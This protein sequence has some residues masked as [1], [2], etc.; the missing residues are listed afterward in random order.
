MTDREKNAIDRW[1]AERRA[2]APVALRES[3]EKV[4]HSFRRLGSTLLVEGH[5]TFVPN[6]RE[7]ELDCRG[8]DALHIN[9]IGGCLHTGLRLFNALPGVKVATIRNQ[10]LSAA[11]LVAMA[12]Q[13]VRIERSAMMMLHTPT[14]A[15][16]G[17]G[18]ELRA[19]LED[20]SFFTGEMVKIIAART[21]QPEA[22]VREWCEGPDRW[23]TAEQCV[24]LGL[25][26]EI[27]EEP[28]EP[29]Q[30]AEAQGDLDRVVEALRKLGRVSCDKAALA[31]ELNHFFHMVEHTQQPAP[32]SI[33]PGREPFSKYE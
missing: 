16:C 7:I 6:L 27:F 31:R 22:T 23:F 18:P 20:I 30:P 17:S 29:P 15:I 19:G 28:A 14:I 33:S 8:V 10:C 32:V 13:T 4:T 1:N 26:D 12:A 11:V 9:S 24:A 25:A 2:L 5:L 21:K 3:F